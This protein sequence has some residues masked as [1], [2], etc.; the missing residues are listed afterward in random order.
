[1]TRAVRVF[2]LLVASAL[3][4][5]TMT[6]AVAADA[7]VI[8]RHAV[9]APHW[10]PPHTSPYLLRHRTE[11]YGVTDA[12]FAAASR[13]AACEEGGNW[14][15]SGPVFDGGIGWTIANWRQ[16]R[17]PDWPLWMHD[18]PPRMQANALFRFA[19][20]YGIG[21]PDQDGVCRGY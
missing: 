12:M 5:E 6:Q 13:V 20:H 8:H 4:I 15:F 1:M 2:A 7:G 14:H 19:H 3:A 10:H 21:L 18:A 11:T 16:F 17:R 9:A